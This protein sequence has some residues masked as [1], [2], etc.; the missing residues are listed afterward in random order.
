MIERLELEAFLT[1]AEELHFGR[2]A[3]RLHVTTG[4]IS[5]TIRALERRIGAPLFDRT[6]RSVRLTELGHALYQDLRPGYEQ[7]QAGLDRATAAVRRATEELTVGYVGA[8]VGQVAHQA[9]VLFPERRPGCR[10]QVREVQIVEA[11]DRLRAGE[12]D[13]LLLSLPLDEP[14]LV[15]GPVLISEP[16]MLAV[17]A[18]H[19]LARQ[20]RVTTEDLARIPLLRIAGSLPGAWPADRRLERTPS[21]RPIADGPKFTTFQEALQLIGAGAGAYVVGA[22]VTRF[23]TRPDTAY[24]P[25]SDA[26]PIEWVPVWL[27]AN[28]TPLLRAFARTAQEVAHRIYLAAT[29]H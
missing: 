13:V 8:A 3:A 15:T 17:P 23:Y 29:H 10:V 7:I 20:D 14:D 28:N 25:F 26:P 5:Q 11:L 12:A 22:Q 21:G 4:R 6:N 18:D 27:K 19:P 24:L 2:T 1:L 9:A 16:R